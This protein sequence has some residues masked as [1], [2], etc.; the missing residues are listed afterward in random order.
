[1]NLKDDDWKLG[2]K[3]PQLPLW[4]G[5][6]FPL[7]H[8]GHKY[9]CT[10]VVLRDFCFGS[11]LSSGQKAKHLGMQISTAIKKSGYLRS[12]AWFSEQECAPGDSSDLVRAKGLFHERGG[13]WQTHISYPLIDQRRQPDWG[14]LEACYE[15]H[16]HWE[17]QINFKSLE[18]QKYLLFNLFFWY[19]INM[20]Y[21][22]YIFSLALTLNSEVLLISSSDLATLWNLR[23]SLPHLSYLLSCDASEDFV[24]SV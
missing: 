6:W 17:K 19:L 12:E 22:P 15:D 20:L 5:F 3:S 21:L 7:N 18:S 4:W 9:N 8:M 1:M 24:F 14:G 16:Q 23:H 2:W 13:L 10:L 11:W